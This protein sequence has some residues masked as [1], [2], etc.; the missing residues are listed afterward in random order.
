MATIAENLTKLQAAR[1]SIADAIVQKGGTVSQGDGFEDFP[2]D[3]AT[4][5]AGGSGSATKLSGEKAIDAYIMQTDEYVYIFGCVYPSG[6]R[7]IIL[8]IPDGFSLGTFIY[9]VSFQHY[10]SYRTYSLYS[11]A[12]SNNEV[13]LQ[14]STDYETTSTNTWMIAVFNI[15]T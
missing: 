1:T 2:S 13:T 7:R 12:I 8:P 11:A 9:G 10:T 6:Y 14:Q 15:S 4:I 3:I 5:P